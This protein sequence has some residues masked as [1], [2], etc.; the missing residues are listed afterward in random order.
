MNTLAMTLLAELTSLMLDVQV[1][2]PDR[3]ATYTTA[4]NLVIPV[5]FIRDLDPD[6]L[7]NIEAARR[8]AAAIRDIIEYE[9]AQRTQPPVE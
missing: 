3:L 9:R 7:D 5:A 4:V 1:N 2:D 8:A 6:D